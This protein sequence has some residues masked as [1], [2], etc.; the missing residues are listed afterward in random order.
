MNRQ[1]MILDYIRQ[2]KNDKG[3]PP[4]VREIGQAVGLKSNSTVH[5]HLER[6]EK[7]GLIKRDPTKPRA[8][9]LIEIDR[10]RVAIHVIE[11]GI[12]GIFKK[13]NIGGHLYEL[14]NEVR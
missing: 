12:D 5:G 13:V 14:V 10:I 9:E 2:N 11:M 7:K 4:T 6:L 3:Y 8:I 1:Q